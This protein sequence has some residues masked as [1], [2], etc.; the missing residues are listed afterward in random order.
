MWI[1]GIGDV[2]TYFY[3]EWAYYTSCGGEGQ[4]NSITIAC[5]SVNDSILYGELD[6]T[7]PP[8]VFVIGV[9]EYE[10]D[11]K[12]YPSPTDGIITVKGINDESLFT[13]FNVL[14]SIVQS[15][16][17]YNEQLDLSGLEPGIYLLSITD[18]VTNKTY[19]SR[20][21]KN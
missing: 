9:D 13:V 1:E 8:F 2:R 11:I 7:L 19:H 6:C 14:G 3:N 15:G 21:V 5:Y 10:S 16:T 4:S 18:I 12:L 20:V 17:T